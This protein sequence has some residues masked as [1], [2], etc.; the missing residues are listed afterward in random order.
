MTRTERNQIE[1]AFRAHPILERHFNAH[2]DTYMDID[3]ILVK[4]LVSKAPEL[5]DKRK[6][7]EALA[8]MIQ[9][10]DPDLLGVVTVMQRIPGG[11]SMD[12][13]MVCRLFAL[14]VVG[15]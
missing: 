14:A 12:L 15:H 7:A 13:A 4:F 6:R 11:S 2:R 8:G 10:A 9:E 5:R 3:R 1:T